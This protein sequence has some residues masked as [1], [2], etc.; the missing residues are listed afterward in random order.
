[1]LVDLAKLGATFPLDGIG[2]A[3]NDADGAWIRE[4][5]RVMRTMYVM[6]VKSPAESQ[7]PWD[8]FRLLATIP[9]DKAFRPAGAGCS[10]VTSG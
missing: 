8:Y 1:M 4:D 6:A 5:G 10:L 7:R 9:P 3:G 2:L